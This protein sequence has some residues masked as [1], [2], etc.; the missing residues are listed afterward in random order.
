MPPG[1]ARPAYL[2]A[3]ALLPDG[4]RRDRA[5]FAAALLAP[6]PAGLRAALAEFADAGSG[7]PWARLARSEERLIRLR[8]AVRGEV[9]P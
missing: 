4:P 6:T 5:R 2:R 7:A 8:A 1:V 3:V 9:I